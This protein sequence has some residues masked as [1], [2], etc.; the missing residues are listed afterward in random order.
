MYD[1]YTS[2]LHLHGFSLDMFLLCVSVSIFSAIEHIHKKHYQSKQNFGLKDKNYW[3][4][5]AK[6]IHGVVS[7]N[8]CILYVYVCCASILHI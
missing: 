3:K 4:F 5:M 1:L 6:K 7:I 2:Y 8:V